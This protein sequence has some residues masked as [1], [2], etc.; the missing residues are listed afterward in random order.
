MSKRIEIKIDRSTLPVDGQEVEWQTQTDIDE[1]QWKRGVFRE[2]DDLF[3]VGFGETSRHFDCMWQ[4]HHWRPYEKIDTKRLRRE[5]MKEAF[6]F[7]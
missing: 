5:V 3:T 7:F 4:V 1:H 2:S 6:R